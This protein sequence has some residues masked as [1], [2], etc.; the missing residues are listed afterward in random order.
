MEEHRVN[1]PI[2]SPQDTK[3]LGSTA[4]SGGQI[5]GNTPAAETENVTA[6]LPA[7]E[8]VLTV[9]EAAERLRIGRTTMYSLV[10]KGEIESVQIGSLR[11]I[12][13][14]ALHAYVQQLMI[15]QNNRTAA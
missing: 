5:L 10:S 13:V 11:R 1:P 9:E 14:S 3:D 15:Q 12:P 4:I 2:Q 8:I 6:L 7:T